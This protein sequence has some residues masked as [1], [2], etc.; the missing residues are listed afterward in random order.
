MCNKDSI[1]ILKKAIKLTL[2]ELEKAN[3]D[4][5]NIKI[6]SGR[7]YESNFGGYNIFETSFVE[8]LIR[9]L[10]KKRYQSPIGWEVAYPEN[11]DGWEKSKLDLGLGLVDDG[12]NDKKYLFKIAIEVKKWN[13]EDTIPY[14]IWEDVFKIIGYSDEDNKD[15]GKH[16]YILLFFQNE[17]K[18]D[19]ENRM[20]QVF[21]DLGYFGN[22]LGKEDFSNFLK[23]KLGWKKEKYIK[24]VL[25]KLDFNSEKKILVIESLET[26]G[27]LGAVLL[28]V[29]CKN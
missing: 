2:S 14:N 23:K 13:I 27:A 20:N 21:I 12:K 9:N 16:K 17:N 3:K 19:I 25:N 10:I 7:G 11:V 6:V 1:A 29:N 24:F 28:K 15:V 8:K 5:E 26:R 22:K 4:N 18:S